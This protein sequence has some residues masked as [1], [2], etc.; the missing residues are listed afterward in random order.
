[1]NYFDKDGDWVSGAPDAADLAAERGD[2]KPAP[3]VVAYW[4]DEVITPEVLIR[5]G[6]EPYNKENPKEGLWKVTGIS[7]PVSYESA[8]YALASGG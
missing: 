3:E 7:K 1:V 8:V 2:V 4:G 5:E 6:Y